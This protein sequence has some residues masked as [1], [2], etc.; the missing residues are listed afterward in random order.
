M[1]SKEE[2]KERRQT[3]ILIAV[4]VVLLCVIIFP[5][6]FYIRANRPMAQAER[7]A[8]EIAQKYAKL[9]SVDKFYWFTQKKT[10]FSLLGSNDSGKEIAVIIP[11]SGDKVTILNQSDGLSEDDVKAL[12]VK[13]Y[14][15]DHILTVELG[16]FDDQPV[17]EI[18]NENADKSLTYYLLAF[19]DGQEVKIISNI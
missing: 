13:Q 8:T 5:T 14:Q 15:A 2:K 16:I 12:A 4:I 7:E 19:S 10:Y 1:I 17:W 18:C 9:E 6:V 11:K 3:N